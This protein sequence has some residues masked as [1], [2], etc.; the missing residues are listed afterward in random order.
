M[1]RIRDILAKP[2]LSLVVQDLFLTET[3]EFA[4]VLLPAAGWGEKT[5]TFTNAARVVH[6]SRQA[7][8][9]PGEARSDL[10]IF[11]DYAAGMG[12]RSRS[13]RPLLD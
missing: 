10:A 13:G 4:D 7:V 5:G 12:F 1:P 6:L 8:E 11:L 9:P 3:S 2:D